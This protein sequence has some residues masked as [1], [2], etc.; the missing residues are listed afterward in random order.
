MTHYNL[1]ATN[2]SLIQRVQIWLGVLYDP[3]NTPRSPWQLEEA[4]RQ[5]V[6]EQ[7]QD[8]KYYAGQAFTETVIKN[9]DGTVTVED[10]RLNTNSHGHRAEFLTAE[11]KA[12]LIARKLTIEKAQ[13]IKPHWAQGRSAAEAAQS[14][15]RRGYGHRTVQEYYAVFN[16]VTPSPESDRGQYRTPYAN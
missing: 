1:I 7:P 3:R 2:D 10:I 4:V 6:R 9:E 12:A 5:Q 14:I 16:A 13:V 15:D 8:V 11:D